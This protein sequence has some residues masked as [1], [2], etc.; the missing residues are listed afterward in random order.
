MKKYLFQAASIAFMVSMFLSCAPKYGCPTNGK[1]LGA[2]RILQGGK[3][4]KARK[5]RV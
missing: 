3:V 2:E 5:M 4:P 1:N